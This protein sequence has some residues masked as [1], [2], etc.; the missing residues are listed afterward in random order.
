M[1]VIRSVARALPAY[2]V[3]QDEMESFIRELFNE[4]LSSLERMLQV[5]EN[6]GIKERQFVM[7]IDWYKK[8][9]GLEERNTLFI[10]HAVDLGTEAVLNC[11]KQ[12]KQAVGIEDID[13][14][15]SVTSS[16]MAAPTLEAR[17]MNGTGLKNETTRIPL[18]GLGCAGGA[19]GLA[20]AYD[21]CLAHPTA[22][23][24]VLCVELCSLTFQRD[25]ISK[26]N[27]V[28][29]S[30][31]GDGVSCALVSGEESSGYCAEG[32]HILGTQA[33]LMPDSERV[34]GWDIKDTG[35]HVVFSR[36]IPSLISTWLR[37]RIES[38]LSSFN[39]DIE[40]TDRWI[41]H[42][43]GRKVLDAYRTSLNVSQEQLAL[44]EQILKWHGNM[45]SP[46]VLYVLEDVMNSSPLKGEVG[47]LGAL[48]PGFSAEMLAMEWR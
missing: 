21:Y 31:F 9:K 47:L 43:G 18:W 35:F 28:G 44:S 17:I 12:T 20:R 34:M 33:E 15:I 27:F 23:V 39:W 14:F 13:A 5:F 42:P 24:L 30:L 1:P 45:S 22:N 4:R 6:G 19:G 7:P 46:S 26:S 37:P 41:L 11:I 36:D 2:H 40:S 16:G 25:D 29:T 3:S 10:E 32:P 8:D 38:F 48:G